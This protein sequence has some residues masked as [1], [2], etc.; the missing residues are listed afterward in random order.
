MKK[1]ELERL[2]KKLGPKLRRAF[3]A[4]MEDLRDGASQAEVIRALQKRDV[5]AALRAMNIDQAAMVTYAQALNDIFNEAGTA[6]VSTFPQL[7]NPQ[8]GK[9][10][11]RFDARDPATEKIIRDYSSKRVKEITDDTLAGLQVILEDGLAKGNGPRTTAQAMIGTLDKSTG[12]RVGS[13]I[14]LTK[15]QNESILKAALELKNDPAA[16]LRRKLRDKRFDRSIRKALREGKPVPADV[17][18]KALGRLK[19]NTLRYRAQSIARTE[20]VAA[21]QMGN[22]QA[23]QQ[24]IDKGLITPEDIEREWSSSGD[25]RVRESHNDMDGQTVAWDEP[26]TTPSGA[27]LMHPC[28]PAGPAEEVINCRCWEIIRINYLRRFQ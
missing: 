4:S 9:A 11:I 8:G 15:K 10:I 23:Y 6:A 17:Q 20:T 18:A 5:Q 7:R 3:L 27:K 1:S 22:R 19:D 21:L 28:D 13:A 14:G 12:K 25:N 16:F 2:L 26:Y 24:A